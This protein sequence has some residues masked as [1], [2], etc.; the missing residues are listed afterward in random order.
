VA[1]DRRGRPQ[2]AHGGAGGVCAGGARLN[3]A[4]QKAG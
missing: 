3:R 4:R 2:P 1:C